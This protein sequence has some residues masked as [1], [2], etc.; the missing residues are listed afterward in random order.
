[1]HTGYPNAMSPTP[2]GFPNAMPPT[3]PGYPHNSTPGTFPIYQPWQSH[4]QPT[5]AHPEI[6]HGDDAYGYQ[7]TWP[8][9]SVEPKQD[10]TNENDSPSHRRRDF[11]VIEVKRNVL[12]PPPKDLPAKPQHLA[13]D[14]RRDGPVSLEDDNI[15]GTPSPRTTATPLEIKADNN[16]KAAAPKNV[17]V[18]KPREENLDVHIDTEEGQNLAP[19]EVDQQY[20][21]DTF[22]L[23]KATTK[24]PPGRVLIGPD[25]R[26]SKPPIE[27]STQVI[28]VIIHSETQKHWSGIKIT[29]YES[30]IAGY[31]FD[32]LK[33][34]R[35]GRARE[36]QS[37]Y[38]EQLQ[39][40]FQQ[41]GMEKQ[42]KMDLTIMVC[43]AYGIVGFKY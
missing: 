10:W 23:L 37:S 3:L 1:M 19:F 8:E 6:P 29:I 16:Q 13:A 31:Y 43:G 27:A 7:A 32:S 34:N 36:V 21:G 14:V 42:A 40:W 35:E 15:I 11:D 18:P 41:V 12:P 4:W 28:V 22:R 20:T 5:E 30:S 2:P 17:P 26:R 24:P 38:E 9:Q 33:S 39:T 25:H